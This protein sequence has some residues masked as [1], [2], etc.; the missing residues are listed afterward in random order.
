MNVSLT[1][2]Q[3]R[4]IQAKVQTGRYHTAAEVVREGL[5]VLMSQ[6]SD[7]QRRFEVWR[8]EVRRK[9]DS[10]MDQAKRGQLVDG[11]QVFDKLK[12]RLDTRRKRRA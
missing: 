8:E 11:Q 3:I 6:D 2:E 12:K 1:D 4:F 5:R 9:I 10:G 7:E